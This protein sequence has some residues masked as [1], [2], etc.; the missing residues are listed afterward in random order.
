MPGAVS[1]F[2]ESGIDSFN[3]ASVAVPDRPYYSNCR[4]TDGRGWIGP[5]FPTSD[6]LPGDPEGAPASSSA[7]RRGLG[8]RTMRRMP[9][10]IVQFQGQESVA[11]LKPGANSI[12]RQSSCTIPL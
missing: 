3:P 10:F 1:R 9:K 5:G 4:S 11:E 6:P 12:G 8:G 7:Y 2:R